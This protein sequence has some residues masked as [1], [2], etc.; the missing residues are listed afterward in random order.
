MLTVYIKKIE[1]M[2]IQEIILDILLAIATVAHAWALLYR[3]LYNCYKNSVYKCF[4][5]HTHFFYTPKMNLFE[6]SIRV[7]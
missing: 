7:Y 5:I 4:I 1:L 2:Y 3:T 6:C